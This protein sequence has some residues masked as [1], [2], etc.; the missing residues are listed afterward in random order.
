MRKKYYKG[1]NAVITGAASGI[2]R[3]IA[4]NLAKMD[5]NLV[6]SDINM[7]RLEQVKKIIESI[8]VKVIA[9]KCN[10]M[11]QKEVENLARTS[12]SEMKDIHF[13]FSNAGIA[14]GGQFEHLS[15]AIWKR[16]ININ[17]WGM[18][19]VVK[20][21][22]SKLLEQGFGHIIVTS[23]VAGTIGTGGLIP[24]NTTKFA[25]AGFC[26]ALYGEYHEKGINVSILCP[27]P[28]KTNLIETAGIS[29]A[30]EMIE[31]LD[32]EATLIGIKEAKK[33][34]W[35]KFTKKKILLSGF[36]GGFPID[37]AVKRYLRRIRRKKL[38]IFERRYG[39]MCQSSKGLTNVIYKKLLR[40]FSKRHMNLL[41]ETFEITKIVTL[42]EM[43]KKKI[44][45]ELK[46]LKP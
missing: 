32:P 44:K 12:I 10:V 17:I 4:I 14:V 26:E 29:V 9:V 37:R 13:L 31:D 1:K 38:Y 39:K 23:S 20:A 33:H 5:V 15:M 30:P 36:G 45:S 11:K 42:K 22:L 41:N 28:I 19:Y 25:N 21:F 35:N 2:G 40:T 18:I 46:E 16:I 7:E 27:F 43:E 24:Y 3:S 6:I 8:G 34:Y